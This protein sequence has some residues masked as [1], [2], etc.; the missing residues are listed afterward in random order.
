MARRIEGTIYRLTYIL[1]H[2]TVLLNVAV[3]KIYSN[4][5]HMR[6]SMDRLLHLL[7]KCVKMEVH[8]K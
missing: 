8:Q 2:G 5:L 6:L 1:Q 7:M 4:T 3:K